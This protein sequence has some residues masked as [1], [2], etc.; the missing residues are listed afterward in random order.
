MSPQA[1][2][3]APRILLVEDSLPDIGLF[4]ELFGAT[5]TDAEL[6]VRRDGESALEYLRGAGRAG[7]GAPADLVVLDLGLP[8]VDGR[9]VLAEIRRDPALQRLAVA[10]LTGSPLDDDVLTAFQYRADAY[11]AKPVEPGELSMLLRRFLGRR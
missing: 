2:P 6:I 7:T 4:R 10:I 3:R 1:P 9:R 5:R 11:L 8:R